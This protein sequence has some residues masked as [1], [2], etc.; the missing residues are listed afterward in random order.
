[1]LVRP[2]VLRV[3]TVSCHWNVRVVV[4]EFFTYGISV[5]YVGYLLFSTYRRDLREPGGKCAP[6]PT[7]DRFFHFLLTKPMPAT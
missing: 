2:E 6:P 3:H 4:A 1:M 7:V 5:S